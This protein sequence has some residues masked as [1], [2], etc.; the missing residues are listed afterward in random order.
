MVLLDEVVE[1]FVLAHQ[2]ADAGVSFHAFNGRRV[3]PALMCG[4]F[5]WHVVQVD[6]PLQ[7]APRCSHISLGCEKK[8]TVS[9]AR[10][11]AR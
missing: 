11:T 2:D 9:S 4:D 6:G 10:S 7:E 3:D 8:S 5:H 1:V